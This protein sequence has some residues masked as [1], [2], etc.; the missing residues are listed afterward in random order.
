MVVNVHDLAFRRFPNVS[1]TIQELFE[2]SWQRVLEE[3]TQ[4]YAPQP[5]RRRISSQLVSAHRLHLVR[6]GMTPQCSRRRAREQFGVQA[7][8]CWQ[9][10]PRTSKNIPAHRAMP[11]YLHDVELVLAGPIG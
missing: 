9:W 11:P 8:L 2:R 4:F 1:Q 7:N 10:A 3:P 5:P 6:W